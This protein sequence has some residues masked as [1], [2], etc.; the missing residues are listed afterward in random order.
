MKKIL[1]L[2]LSIIIVVTLCGCQATYNETTN[3]N[4]KTVSVSRNVLIEKT[5]LDN[6]LKNGKIDKYDNEH[7]KER[8]EDMTIETQNGIKYYHY[9]KAFNQKFFDFKNEYNYDDKE[10]IYVDKD[11]YYIDVDVNWLLASDLGFEKPKFNFS[12]TS[13]SQT[14]C[15]GNKVANSNG[16]IDKNNGKK[17]TFNYNLNGVKR[18]KVF[19]STKKNNTLLNIEKMIKESRTIGK[20]KIKKLKAKKVKKNSKTATVV[21]KLKKVKGAQSYLVVYSTSKKM[22]SVFEIS[23][24]KRTVVVKKLKKGKRYYFK[25]Y[26]SKRDFTGYYHSGKACKR[27]SIKTKK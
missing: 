2:L 12:K 8:K 5:Y 19:A 10:I 16:T 25:A 21:V 7:I 27:K 13:F 4:K 11:T 15:F 9:K 24:K 17:V 6:Y 1:S 23:S 18:I 22:K 26:A 14:L 3:I 20:T